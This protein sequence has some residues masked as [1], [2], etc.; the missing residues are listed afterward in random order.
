M[1]LKRL[2]HTLVCAALVTTASAQLSSNPD[3]FLGNITTSYQV[4]W[5]KEKF[6]TLWNQITPENE[7]KWE[8]IEGSRRG[9]FD[10][11]RADQ[12]ANYAKKYGFPFKFHTLIWGG[13]Y[14]GWMN[15][16][17]VKEHRR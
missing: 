14:P 10:F 17:S 8:S 6:Y 16:L 4:D 1:Y 7:T 12:S 9:S 3:K 13:Q 5:G 11:A 15:N 2:F